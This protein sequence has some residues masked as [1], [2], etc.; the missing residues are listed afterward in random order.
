MRESVQDCVERNAR[1]THFV[2]FDVFAERQVPALRRSR[3]SA[4]Q[5][6]ARDARRSLAA[7]SPREGRSAVRREE[8]S[9]VPVGLRPSAIE[10]R[11]AEQVHEHTADAGRARRHE[12]RGAV[13]F[14]V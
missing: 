2:E 11:A 3:G 14:S 12:K 10:A 13:L 7:F 9:A 4:R 6:P 5:Q 8:A 1:S